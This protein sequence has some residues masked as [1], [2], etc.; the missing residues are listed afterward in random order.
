MKRGLWL[1]LAL[2]LAGCQSGIESRD[3]YWA[4]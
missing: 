2:L 3:G 1:I 4:D